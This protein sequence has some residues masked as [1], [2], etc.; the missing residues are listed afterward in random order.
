MYPIMEQLTPCSSYMCLLKMMHA[1]LIFQAGI[2]HNTKC[3][4]H[5]KLLKEIYT[6]HH[7]RVI[8]VKV[9]HL[10]LKQYLLL[11]GTF[12]IESYSIICLA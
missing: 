3:G 8:F 10:K 4:K 6:I 5:A 1:C 2:D 9:Y 12:S 11:L 7:I